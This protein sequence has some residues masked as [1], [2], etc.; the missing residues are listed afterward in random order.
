MN[1]LSCS[2][3]FPDIL[4]LQ[5]IWQIHDVNT[6]PISGYDFV[7]KKR[8]KFRGGGVG[9]YVKKGIQ[10][11]IIERHSIFIEKIFECITLELTLNGKKI[12]ICNYYRPPTPHPNYTL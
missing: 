5:E 10:Y 6:V 2:N 8:S 1:E 4:C 12:I 7:Y 11:K 9:C 3:I